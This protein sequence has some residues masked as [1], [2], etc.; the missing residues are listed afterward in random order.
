VPLHVVRYIPVIGGVIL[1]Y[2][3]LPLL[4]NTD[5]GIYCSMNNSGI[6]SS[7]VPLDVLKRGSDGD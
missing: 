7:W 5:D 4:L 3:I 1:L 6:H 2:N